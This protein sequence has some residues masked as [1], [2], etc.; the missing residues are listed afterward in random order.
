MAMIPTL[1]FYA[2]LLAALV[3][4]FLMR[5]WLWPNNPDARFQ[6]IPTPQLPRHKRSREPKPFVG[7]SQKP[8]SAQFGHPPACGGRW[9]S[10]PHGVQT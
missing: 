7:L 3:W 6:P 8:P 5:Y 4:L 1:F 9:S 2:F 10:G